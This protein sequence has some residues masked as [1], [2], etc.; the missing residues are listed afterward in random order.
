MR[1]G[2]VARPEDIHFLERA[3]I[4]AS[5]SRI[6]SVAERRA[7]WARNRRLT[8]PLVIGTLPRPS[9]SSMGTLSRRAPAG[10]RDG[11]LRGMPASAG[12]ATGVARVLLDL[13]DA[14]R[15][16]PGE[17]LVTVATTPAWTPLFSRAERRHG[18]RESRRARF[19][20]GTRVW[21]PRSGRARR[22][23]AVVRD[24]QRITIDRSTGLLELHE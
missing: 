16:G 12:R 19:A 21:D 15:L 3:E 5:A 17:I 8:P 18:R 22:R 10:T 24:G 1:R 13:A 6:S 11:M 9:R 4:E 7:L 23:R 14:E 2:V 20:R